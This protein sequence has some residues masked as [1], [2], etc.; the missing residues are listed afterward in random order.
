MHCLVGWQKMY[1][2]EYF[3]RIFPHFH[4]LQIIFLQ[5]SQSTVKFHYR[6][7]VTS[8]IL[9]VIEL[10]QRRLNTLFFFCW[11]T[12]ILWISVV[13]KSNPSKVNTVYSH[14]KKSLLFFVAAV[15]ALAHNQ[16]LSSIFSPFVRSHFIIRIYLDEGIQVKT[17]T[18][19][20]KQKQP[21]ITETLT[22]T[23]TSGAV[24]FLSCFNNTNKIRKPILLW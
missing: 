22:L 1:F 16:Q 19:K 7:S 10:R 8:D 2:H 9:G 3:S 14:F 15:I 11:I 20:Q 5:S 21:K 13:K 24:L 12:L 18:T 4:E 6:M 17:S 23:E